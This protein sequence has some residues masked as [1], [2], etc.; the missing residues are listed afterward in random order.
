ARVRPTTIQHVSRK[1]QAELRD[2][3]LE[4]GGLGEG[5]GLG[6]RD[7]EERRSIRHQELANGI[8]M[9]AHSPK[10]PGE[11]S[12]EVLQVLEEALT[13][14]PRED[15]L[16]EICRGAKECPAIRQEDADDPLVEEQ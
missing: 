4:E 13:E 6:A 11:G 3:V 1:R 8:R 2:L 7:E 14:R 5:R 15:A 9:R 10:H 12:E 16:H